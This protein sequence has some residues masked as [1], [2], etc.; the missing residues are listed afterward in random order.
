MRKIVLSTNIAETSITIDDIVFVVDCGKA[1]EKTYD[2]VNKLCCL[3]PTW[4]SCASVRQRRKG[5][6]GEGRQVLPRVHQGAPR[7]S[8]GAVQLPEI[9][10][11]PEELCLQIK[12]LQLGNIE[13]FLGRPWSPPTCCP[14]TTRWSCWR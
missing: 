3:L 2:A 14:S 7:Q 12:S 6:Q 1:K 10:R 13:M 9:L 4:V 5:R 8:D 11:T